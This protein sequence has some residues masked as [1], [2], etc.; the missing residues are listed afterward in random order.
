MNIDDMEG[1][2]KE[3]RKEIEEL[4]TVTRE[5]ESDEQFSL[6]QRKLAE[7]FYKNGLLDEAVRVS[8]LIEPQDNREHYKKAQYNIATVYEEQD[9]TE[10]ALK[11]WSKI[12]ADSSEIYSRAQYNIG[13]I[14]NDLGEFEEAKNAWSKVKKSGSPEAYARAQY[15]LASRLV[16]EGQ[17]DNAIRAWRNI[18]K[19]DDSEIYALAQFNIGVSL[20]IKDS[21]YEALETWEKIEAKDSLEAFNR[22][23]YNICT[24]SLENTQYQDI[25]RAENALKKIVNGYQ[26]EKRCLEKIC[27]LLK[28][29]STDIG[30]HL[31]LLFIRTTE[32][33]EI[34]K[35]DFSHRVSDNKPVERKLAHYTGTDTTNK[36]LDIEKGKEQPSSFR[37]NTI[38]N[39]ND[40]SEG[41]LLINYLKEIKEDFSYNSQFDENL[42]AFIS[43]F[44]FNHDSLNQ[45]RLYGKQDNKEA[46]GISLVFNEGF[47]QKYNST[48][49]LSYV[50]FEDNSKEVS[51]TS[52]Q[53][54]VDDKSGKNNIEAINKIKK[55]PV[56]RCVYL[57]PTSDYI[58][59]AQRNRLTF[60]R[61]FNDEVVQLESEQISKAEHEWKK[62][63]SFID[64]KT[65]DFRMAFIDLRI[66]YTAIVEELTK[67][68][69]RNPSLS[70]RIKNLLNGILLPLKYLIKHSAFQEEQEC[71][72]VYMTS[73]DD[74][75]V[76]MDFGKFLYVEYEADVK[77]NLDKIYI[78]PAAIQYQPYLA[79]LLCN[80]NV[81]IELSNNPYRQT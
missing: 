2:D 41:K 70:G 68:E 30:K 47:F 8:K 21:T 43:C 13:T 18:G 34:L 77:S 32:I 56:M 42:H 19:K 7:I 75:K 6:A 67:I 5:S 71:R 35:V 31:L 58:H 66:A 14:K 79:K 27:R 1:L 59:L 76:Q 44:T 65:E 55:Q 23:Q 40:P 57:D 78:A 46:S 39:V 48:V 80:T 4:L 12:E 3:T 28:T 25:N 61:E 51:I 33:I 52:V 10:E 73:L 53:K 38:N 81:K 17:E 29:S 54:H 49:G 26:Y 36:L 37:L 15:N 22:A 24:V 50:A 20:N 69:E 63:Q 60:F 64:K 45:F 62:Y 72:M 74:E 16:K 9:K 11:I